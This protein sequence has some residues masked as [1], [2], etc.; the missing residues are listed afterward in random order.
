MLGGPQ[1]IVGAWFAMLA[2]AS[3]HANA[4]HIMALYTSLVTSILQFRRASGL[5]LEI[6][7]A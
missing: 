2:T 5:C 4:V 6:P 7:A 1:S 3:Y